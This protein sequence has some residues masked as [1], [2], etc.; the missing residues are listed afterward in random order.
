MK[1]DNGTITVTIADHGAEI[2]SV[3]KNGTE[4]MWCGDAKYWN[5]T[6]PVLFPI[7]GGLK[8]KK[9]TYGE[10]EYQMG[11][12]GFARDMDFEVVEADSVSATYVLKS[13]EE[14]LEKYPFEF[15]FTIKYILENS[16]IRVIWQVK[17]QT[18]GKMY[19]SI[20][21][22]P[23][24]NLREGKNYFSFDRE[25]DLT[26]HLIDEAGLYSAEPLYTLKNDGFV[27]IPRDMF[28][29]DALIMEN[30]QAKAVSLCDEN[31]K[32]YVTV[33]FSA[34]V[35]GLW[36]KPD[37]APFVC[38]EPWYGRCDS[39]VASGDFTEKDHIQV[40]EKDGV[41]EAEYVMD[42]KGE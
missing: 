9:Y 12:H 3:V 13:N 8:D 24:F 18:D 27:P 31:K 32:P 17:N 35:F 19:F 16:A 23:A 10:K 34:E 38:I 37:G 40:L 41:F 21:A 14:P 39:N 5:R 6:A 11:Q 26:Y 29:R 1:L 28:N 20:G 42:F 15:E 7:V 30:G 33:S 4:Y 25:N 36:S 2:K 22:H